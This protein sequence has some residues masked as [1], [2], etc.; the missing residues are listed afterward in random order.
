MDKRLTLP[1]WVL[2]LAVWPKV[3][4]MPQNLSAQFVYQSLKVWDFNEKRFHWASVVRAP[5]IYIRNKSL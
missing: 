3:P 1:K 2:I 5:I 4:Q